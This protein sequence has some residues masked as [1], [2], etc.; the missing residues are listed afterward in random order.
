MVPLWFA[1]FLA[2]WAC[3]STVLSLWH[4]R[5]ERQARA[6]LAALEENMPVMV[7]L[8]PDGVVDAT[9]PV[10]RACYWLN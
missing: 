6:A 1:V 7:L 2:G 9:L 4:A 3:G 8:R 5:R 10:T